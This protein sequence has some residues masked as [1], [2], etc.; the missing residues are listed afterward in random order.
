MVGVVP[1]YWLN[2][3]M[4]IAVLQWNISNLSLLQFNKL[5]G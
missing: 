2:L 3:S 5:D 1:V 4:A